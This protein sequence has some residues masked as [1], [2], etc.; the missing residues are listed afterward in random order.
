MEIYVK[1]KDD[2]V[3]SLWRSS[4]NYNLVSFPANLF[5]SLSNITNTNL[6][7]RILL[8][9]FFLNFLTLLGLF[10]GA[11]VPFF[12]S[13]APLSYVCSLMI[14]SHLS[15]IALFLCPLSRIC[16]PLCKQLN[17]T[18]LFRPASG[19]TTSR[20]PSMIPPVCVGCLCSVFL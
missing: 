6:I 14:S 1:F 12:K 11:D 19:I 16:P 18:H 10:R 17:P 20:K 3:P 2:A 13:S 4:L 15:K 8:D 5:F 9:Y 7:Q